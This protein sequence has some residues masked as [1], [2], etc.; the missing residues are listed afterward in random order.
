[1]KVTLVTGLLVM[2]I[3]GAAG[4]ALG[5]WW[6]NAS[7][8]DIC[9]RLQDD[10]GEQA[11]PM[12]DCLQGRQDALIRNGLAATRRVR[13]CVSEAPRDCLSVTACIAAGGDR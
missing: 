5:L 2:L 9:Q 12:E 13:T 1:M 11:M 7:S 3:G 4:A 8:H 6:V 10:C